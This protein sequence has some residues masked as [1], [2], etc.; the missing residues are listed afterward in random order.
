MRKFICLLSVLAFVPIISAK[1]KPAKGKR[2]VQIEVI[3]TKDDYWLRY[4]PGTNKKLVKEAH[5]YAQTVFIFADGKRLIMTCAT[6]DKN[7]PIITPN[8]T[9]TATEQDGKFIFLSTPVPP[10][11]DDER[12]KFMTSRFRI[13]EGSW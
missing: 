2:T 12:A 6:A 13:E 5:S 10:K 1:P 8:E 7:C 9:L 4:T 3:S 11:S